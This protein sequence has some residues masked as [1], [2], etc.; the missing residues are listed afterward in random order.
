M[1]RSEFSK[2]SLEPGIP[3]WG[4]GGRAFSEW[5]QEA[6]FVIAR[7]MNDEGLRHRQGMTGNFVLSRGWG[8]RGCV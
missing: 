4:R 8:V 1:S 7:R 5:A 3:S 2:A 6:A